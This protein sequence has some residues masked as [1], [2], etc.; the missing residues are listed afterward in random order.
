MMFKS[1]LAIKER[2]SGL[3]SSTKFRLFSLLLGFVLLIIIRKII[4]A[5]GLSLGYLYVTLISL[6]GFWFG[7]RGGLTA[8]T[9]ASLIFLFELNIFKYWAFR[10]IVVKGIFLR[11]SVYLLAGIIVGYLAGVEKRLRQ[12]LRS[13]AYQ[14]ELTGCVNF[15]WTMRFL[16]NEIA[17][18]KRYNKE[19]TII[20]ADIDHFKKIN[21]TYGHLVGNDVLKTFAE[22]IKSNVRGVDIVGRYGG[23]EFLIVLPEASPNQALVAMERIRSKLSQIKITSSHLKEDTE[24]SI[25]FSAGIASFP[26]NGTDI[27]DLIGVADNALY[28]AKRRGR[29]C[30]VIERR[31]WVRLKPVLDLK[32]EIA[33]YSGEEGLQAMEVANISCQGVLLLFPRDVPSQE[34]LCRIYFPQEHLPSEFRCKV[35]HKKRSNKQLYR[36][37]VYFVDIPTDIQKKIAISTS[38]PAGVR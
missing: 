33:E 27:K 25:K 19:M 34:C 28:E 18:S 16:E 21:D 24:F 6:S 32:I 2:F 5:F 12:K 38:S 37:G 9:I 20:M 29:D 31:R 14:D 4:G 11:F 30:I 3:T 13:L 23:E 22:V 1:I 7:I 17:R 8:A 10:D 35:I 36:V 15:R 26:Q